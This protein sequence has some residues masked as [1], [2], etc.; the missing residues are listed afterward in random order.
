MFIGVEGFGPHEW[1]S[2]ERTRSFYRRALSAEFELQPVDSAAGLLHGAFDAVLAFVGTH[3]WNVD[4][5]PDYPILFAMH[6]GAI[7]DREFLN[8]HLPR[9][10]TSDVLIV[11]CTSDITILRRFFGD[12][13]PAFCHLPLPVDTTLFHVRDRR[14]CR[15]ALDIENADYVVGFVG[16]LLPQRNLH[17]FLRMLAE[18]KQRLAPQKVMG[19]V[20][21][22]YWVD[23]PI[24]NY[25]TGNYQPY[26]GN[27][28]R[29]LKLTDDVAHFRANLSD[30]DLALCYGAM[31]CL[32]H[33]TNS[34]DENFGYVPIE[35]MA[36]G[37]PVLAAAYGG[38]K[39]T[40]VHGETGFLMDT[41]STLSGIRMDLISGIE[42]ATRLLLD[43]SLAKEMGRA[44]IERVREGY[45]EATC[46][47]K[48]VAAVKQAIAQHRAGG[49]QPVSPVRFESVP[50]VAGL[51]PSI[52]RPWEYYQSVVSNYVSGAA[53]VPSGESRLRVAAPLIAN[54]SGDYRLDD[55]AW[56]ATFR[57]SPHEFDLVQRCRA[58]ATTVEVEQETNDRQVIGHLINQ[59]LLLCSD[60]RS[61][62]L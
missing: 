55:P 49:S 51:L 18:L 20:V 54:G 8:D 7:L 29:E 59:G 43:T 2:L 23:Y 56:P 31:D 61:P 21:G 57:L 13:C 26:I 58:V 10:R 9:L 37:V 42:K 53:P 35:A 39:D 48:L 30:E 44:G 60:Q 17:Q 25:P 6:G 3:S 36:S 28:L 24:L 46:A 50:P 33:P 62:R 1:P 14:E 16:R 32:I 22:N 5:H 34:I 38:V 47:A 15:A 12:R 27:L 11:N 19:V 52:E 40:V 4:P 45:V 41:W